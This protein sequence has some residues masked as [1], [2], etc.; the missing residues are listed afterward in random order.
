MSRFDDETLEADGWDA[1]GTSTEDASLDSK[2]RAAKKRLTVGLVHEQ[3]RDVTRWIWE[4]SEPLP[5]GALNMVDVIRVLLD[6]LLGDDEL[7]ARV[8]AKIEEKAK[9]GRGHR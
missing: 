8:L 5:S 2:E 1:S 3:H 4:H 6:E 9:R 7:Q